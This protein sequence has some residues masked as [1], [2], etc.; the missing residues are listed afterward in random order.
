MVEAIVSVFIGAT[1]TVAV[2][3]F[4]MAGRQATKSTA[5]QVRAK[6][7]GYGLAER[8]TMELREATLVQISDSGN[9]I[10]ITGVDGIVRRATFDPGMDD[11]PYTAEDNVIIWNSDTSGQ[12]DR[13]IASRVSPAFGMTGLLPIF[14]RNGNEITIIV[15]MGD[16]FESEELDRMTGLGRQGYELD[17]TVYLRNS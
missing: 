16:A 7:D 3:G 14:S 13:V 1:V 10:E 12:H 17:T 15:R 4:F 11:N 8:L 6:Q 2:M 5:Q 9:S